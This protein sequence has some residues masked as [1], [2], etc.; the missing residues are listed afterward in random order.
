M[1]QELASDSLA[2]LA[3]W[4]GNRNQVH[5]VLQQISQQRAGLNLCQKE[6]AESLSAECQ[7]FFQVSQTASSLLGCIYLI[8]LGLC[9][10]SS[11]Y[12]PRMPVDLTRSRDSW[13]AVDDCTQARNLAAAFSS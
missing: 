8:L 6:M 10:M 2:F 5:Q 1:I 13:T 3:Q 11:L 4:D 12:S 9:Y 7:A